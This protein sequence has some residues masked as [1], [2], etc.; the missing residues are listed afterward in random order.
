[1][2]NNLRRLIGITGG[3]ATGKSTV[4]QYLADTYKLPILDADLYAREA[5]QTNSPILFNIFKR[6]G[7]R[8]QLP[9]GSLNR[10]QLGEIIFNNLE[11]KNWLESQIHP[12]VRERFQS[13][14][15]RTDA[16]TI[17]LVI[18][19]LFEAKMTDLITEIWLIYC[20]FQEQIRRLI[21]RDKLSKEQA[22]ARIQSQIPIEEKVAWADVILDNSSTLE[23]LFRQI[24]DAFCQSTNLK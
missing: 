13:E 11:E 8:V 16:R 10:K 21:E 1:M 2:S 6:Y 14:I 15:E 18:P 23:N 3:I 9:D 4:S 24:D 7:D 17:A 20:S 12:Y 5:V 19:L 22:I